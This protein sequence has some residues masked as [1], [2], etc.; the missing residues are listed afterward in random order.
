MKEVIVFGGKE[1]GITGLTLGD[2]E[3]MQDE[4]FNFY[5]MSPLE[6][7]NGGPTVLREILLKCT[8]LKEED[9]GNMEIA[10]L[11]G[12]YAEIASLTARQSKAAQ[13]PVLDR[14]KKDK[15][16]LVVIKGGKD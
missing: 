7:A 1:I 2:V 15:L 3:K 10:D 5:D 16:T 9:L 13:E 4:G 12:L 8:D 11:Y 6:T 14:M